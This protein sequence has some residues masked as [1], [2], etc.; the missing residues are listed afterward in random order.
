MQHVLC[1]IGDLIG[2]RQIAD[3]YQFQLRLRRHLQKL[4]RQRPDVASP[5]TITLGDEFQA[6]YSESERIFRDFLW[7]QTRIHPVRVRFSIGAG[8]L[9]TPLNRKSAIGM[10]GPAFHGAREGMNLLKKAQCFYRITGIGSLH[11]EWINDALALVSDMVESWNLNRIK[12][13]VLLMD[14]Y[15]PQQ[16]AREMGISVPAVYKSIKAGSVQTIIRL[17]KHI[18]IFLDRKESLA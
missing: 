1:V 17:L 6:V 10:D 7:I 12:L 14:G 4:S 16:I 2:S 13:A 18:A 5:Y 15:K 8:T 11:G 9:D 3:R